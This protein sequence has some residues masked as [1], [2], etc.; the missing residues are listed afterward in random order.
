[1][2]GILNKFELSK[3]QTCLQVVRSCLELS[4][5]GQLSNKLGKFVCDWKALLVAVHHASTRMR[6]AV[7]CIIHHN[8]QPS[9]HPT[10]SPFLPCH[11]RQPK[12]GGTLHRALAIPPLVA[13]CDNDD[14][15]SGEADNGKGETPE[16]HVKILH[17]IFRDGLLLSPP[18]NW[19]GA[20]RASL[21]QATRSRQ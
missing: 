13:D 7:L 8:P 1:M 9:Y 19:V 12:T 16:E 10:L 4:A 21:G 14:Y 5:V 18:V 2:W 6:A 15:D 3:K 17:C 20:D 11:P